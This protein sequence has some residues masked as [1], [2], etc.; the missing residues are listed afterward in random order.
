MPR[1][2]L[3]KKHEKTLGLYLRVIFSVETAYNNK[4]P[5]NNK[6]HQILRNREDLVYEG[7]HIIRFKC[8][9]F[10][11]PKKKNH[12]AYKEIGKYGL[13][14]GKNKSSETVSVWDKFH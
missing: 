7:Y 5:S 10:N 11:N 6:K 3:R 1:K 4:R 8:L 9:V 12:M 13:F 14:K 2:R